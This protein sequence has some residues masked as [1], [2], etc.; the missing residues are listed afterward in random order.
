MLLV[1][2]SQS[3]PRLSYTFDWICSQWKLEYEI[4]ERTDLFSEFTGAKISYHPLF[5]DT[6]SIAVKP[7]G[8]LSEIGVKHQEV[9]YGQ[10]GK[11]PVLFRDTSPFGFDIL[12]AIFY[13]LSRY[14][15][16][17]PFQPDQHG[18]FPAK[19]S[20]AVHYGFLRLPV[21]DLW[22]EYF[23][24]KLQEQF[25]DL[26][27][28]LRSFDS[29]TSYDID[30]AYKYKGKSFIRNLGGLAKDLGMLSF[31][32]VFERIDVS[33]GFRKDPWDFYSEILSCNKDQVTN[34]VFFF[35]VGKQT[36]YDRNL[37]P[38]HPDISELIRK[39][40]SA[41]EIGL[42]PSFYSTENPELIAIEKKELEKIIGSEVTKS[43]QHFLKF[44]LPDTYLALI[45]WGIAS[46]FS[47]AYPEVPGFRAG[48]AR[49]FY[50]YDLKNE[51]ST[52]LQIFPPCWMDSTFIQYL[53]SE[54]GAALE[55]I[56]YFLRTVVEHKG[57]FIP[58]FHNHTFEDKRWLEVH[59][60]VVG[61]IQKFKEQELQQTG[62]NDFNE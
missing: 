46:D 22:M 20:V 19:L 29:I 40:K 4:T 34:P 7:S 44:R 18:R 3:S 27:F 25:P 23:R 50:F 39:I 59:E 62:T 41:A 56:K 32:K 2:S 36:D 31:R 26:H 43:R 14:E 24:S 21:V 52:E 13:M 45:A 37:H 51:C 8:L 35:P 1:L 10:I 33:L 49:S 16:Y 53:G 9:N 54:P 17:L 11:M 30:L 55:E 38:H 58:I 42:H 61:E 28:H 47:M 5:E 15:E 6:Q 48:T 60:C 12:S 57:I